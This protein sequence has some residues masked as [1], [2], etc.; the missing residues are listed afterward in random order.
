MPHR[1]GAHVSIEGGI[2]RAIERA[3]A[4]EATALQVFVGSNRA[5]RSREL[6]EAEVARFRS[7]CARSGLAPA[8][9]A[10]SSYLINL[11]APDAA[12]WRRSIA[13]FVEELRRCERLEIPYLVVHPGAHCGAGLEAGLDRAAHALDEAL[14]PGGRASRFSGVRVLLEIT[15]GQGTSLGHRFEQLAALFARARSVERLG[16]CFDT[17]H[18]LAAGYDF[19]DVRSY[20][21]TLAE[22]ER[23]IGLDRLLGFHLN[24][25]V[26]PLGSR[27]DRH[28]HIGRGQVGL[29]GFRRILGDRRFRA[30]PMVLETPKGRDSQLDRRNLAVLRGLVR[31]AR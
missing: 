11:A 13:A 19:R 28:A 22:I 29:E 26:H 25:S 23:S 4:L 31:T 9:M 12:L 18:V 27:R 8:T 6:S 20:R 1:L 5:W 24:D 7:A 17:C 14:G 21:S 16:V 10:H 15:A 3:L 30:T 2:D